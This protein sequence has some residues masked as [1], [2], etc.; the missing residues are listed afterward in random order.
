LV[1]DEHPVYLNARLTEVD[2]RS[3]THTITT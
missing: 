3:T 1:A 2:R